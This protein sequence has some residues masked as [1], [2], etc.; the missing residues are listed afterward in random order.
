V[1]LPE[2]GILSSSLY[3]PGL[4]FSR[5]ILKY[6]TC[7]CS[8]F[9]F[10]SCFQDCFYCGCV[11]TMVPITMIGKNSQWI[12]WVYL[13]FHS[14]AVYWSGVPLP[15]PH[16]TIIWDKMK[17]EQK[18]H[19]GDNLHFCTYSQADDMIYYNPKFQ[20]ENIIPIVSCSIS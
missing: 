18:W 6:L 16:L 8:K 14:V 2:R 9:L 17:K 11:I 12:L 15:S 1:Q 20:L 10:L 3:D 4:F 7:G 5:Y 19:G 13:L